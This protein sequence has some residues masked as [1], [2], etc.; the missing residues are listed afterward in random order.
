MSQN[1]ATAYPK[2]VAVSSRAS[3]VCAVL[4]AIALFGW[5]RT[6]HAQRSVPD[7]A[8]ARP[9]SVAARLRRAEEAITLLQQQLGEAS[10]SGVS[11]RS[12][13]QLELSGRVLVHT[14]FNDHRVNNVDD[15]QF[16]RPDSASALPASAL[17]LA[18]R[19]TSLGV[20]L[21]S[22][23][24]LG[25]SFVG[26]LDA[27]FYG[28]QQP[29]SG[30]R[31]F[32][33][34][35]IRTARGAVRWANGEVMVGQDSP[36]I[37]ALNPVS[38]AAIGTPEFVTAGNLWLWLPQARVTVRTAGSVNVGLQAAVLA[39]TTGDAVGLFD[40]DADPA[41]RSGRPA[42]EARVR[43]QWGDE[44]HISEI[45]CGGHLAWIAMP[46]GYAQSDAVACDVRII[47][48]PIELRGEGYSGHALRGLGGGGISQNLTVNAEP[49]MDRGGWGQLNVELSPMLRFG[50]GCGADKPDGDALAPTA[51]LHN[52]SCSGYT[53]LRPGGPIFIGGEFRRID[54]RYASG[55]VGN[56]HFNLAMGFEF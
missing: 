25:G 44:G 39:S 11:T 43:V 19:Q 21:T 46:V 35:R 32:P 41:E 28:G 47:V 4:A 1:V 9:D 37:A 20:V 26:D 31:T 13:M 3:S 30:G 38:P 10:A 45:G 14:F 22:R 42:T 17:G 33:L 5:S 18:I 40:T 36:L 52:Q 16:V 7:S 55:T 29:S 12:R 2:S 27:D 49:L 23:D 56:N 8:R 50:G 48:G 53:I 51:R 24:V 15:P 34:L 54:T 6:A